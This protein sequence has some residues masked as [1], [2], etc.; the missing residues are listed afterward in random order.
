MKYFL[1]SEG[2]LYKTIKTKKNRFKSIVYSIIFI[3]ILDK[4]AKK[5]RKYSHNNEFRK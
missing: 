2:F 5:S 4:K 3:N 1:F